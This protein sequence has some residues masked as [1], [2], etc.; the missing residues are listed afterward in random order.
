[1]SDEKAPAHQE[2]RLVITSYS[3]GSATARV[4][5]LLHSGSFSMATNQHWPSGAPTPHDLELL[6]AAL[7]DEVTTLI[8]GT[9]GVQGVL[10]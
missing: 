3:N 7:T 10:T 1:M 2:V 8:V 6:I 9:H 5:V 4:G